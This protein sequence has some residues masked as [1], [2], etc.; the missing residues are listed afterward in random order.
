MTKRAVLLVDD[1]QDILNGL[2]ARLYAQRATWKM[3]FAAGGKQ[4][5]EALAGDHFDVIVSD[6]RMPE[7]DGAALLRKVQEQYPEVVRIVLSGQADQETAVRAV[8]VAHQFLAKPC[9]PGVLEHVINRACDLRDV[10]GDEQVSSIVGRVETLPPFPRLYSQLV[11][12]LADEHATAADVARILSQ[13]VA[14]CA[15]TLQMVNSAFFRISRRITKVEEAVVYLG[16]GTVKQLV[17]A[18]E[19]FACPRPDDELVEFLEQLQDHA[20]WVARAAAA[21]APDDAIREEAFMAGLLHDIGKLVLAV[22]LPEVMDEVLATAA[23]QGCTVMAAEQAVFGATH[24]EIG[25]YLLGLWGLPLQVVE[26]VAS[27]HRP[28]RVEAN[29]FGVL[30][31]THL[32]DAL[33]ATVTARQAG[34]EAI[35][36]PGLD[37]AFVERLGVATQIEDWLA[38]VARLGHLADEDPG[39]A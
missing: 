18:A 25:G 16:L 9:E 39:A 36:H 38:Q 7:M 5:L 23:D 21:L 30:A 12:T 31:S 2:K 8:P 20:L 15:K 11:A 34:E 28:S 35:P 4:A 6:M 1:D 22:E 32:A 24:A 14:M 29:G 13:D 27:H 33:V 37:H 10:V 17:L 3:S 19:V 26:A